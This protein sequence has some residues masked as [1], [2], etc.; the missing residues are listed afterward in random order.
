[1]KTIKKV[2]ENLKEEDMLDTQ[3]FKEGYYQ[4]NNEIIITLNRNIS[5]LKIAQKRVADNFS[6][7]GYNARIYASNS[8]AIKPEKLLENIDNCFDI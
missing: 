3:F 8:V 6:K 5:C 4:D 7:K 1:M 2:I